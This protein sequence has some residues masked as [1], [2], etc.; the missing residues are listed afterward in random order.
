MRKRNVHTT[1]GENGGWNV[2]RE[3]AE[4]ASKHFDKKVEAEQFG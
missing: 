3:G 1:P 2:K 4:R